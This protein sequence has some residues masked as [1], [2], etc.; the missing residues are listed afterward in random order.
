MATINQL[1]AN[2][3]AIMQQMAA[4][5]FSPPQSIAVP[6]FNVP[7]IQNVTIPNQQAFTGGGFNP[8]MG[9]AHGGSRCQGNRHG[10]HDGHGRRGCN[11][12]ANHMANLGCGLGQQM[13]QIRGFSGAA[14]P[15]SL[16]PPQ[17]GM[18]VAGYHTPTYTSNTTT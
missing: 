14:I 7:P 1:L 6:A 18:S 15:G 5:S 12:F 11:P 4:M 2:Q 8:G 17:P 10:G 3:L 9:N 16:P 13:P